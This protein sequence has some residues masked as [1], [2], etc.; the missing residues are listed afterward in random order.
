MDKGVSIFTPTYNRAYIL[1]KLYE[2]L[3]KQT[4]GE[5]E[6][7]IVDDGSTDGT[8]QIIETYIKEEKI[9]MPDLIQ[10]CMNAGEKV[11]QVKIDE[12]EWYDMGQPK[13]LEKMKQK[14]GIL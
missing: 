14:L 5:F 9:D 6:W 3:K 2:S 11:G 1:P 4:C 13:E 12:S 10:R 7:I 8:K